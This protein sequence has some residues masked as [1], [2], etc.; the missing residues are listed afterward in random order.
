MKADVVLT[1]GDYATGPPDSDRQLAALLRRFLAATAR[2]KG[3]EFYAA[4][5]SELAVGLH[6]KAVLVDEIV[7]ADVVEARMLAGWVD[8]K[9]LLECRF[10]VAETP[11]AEVLRTNGFVRLPRPG[12]RTAGDPRLADLAFA[13][14]LAAPL[15]SADG[16]AIGVLAVVSADLAQ[17]D[18]RARPVLGFFASCAAA[19]LERQRVITALAAGEARYRSVLETAADAILLVDSGGTIV[20]ANTSAELMFAYPPGSLEGQCI[21]L[22]VPESRRAGHAAHRAR[23][24]AQPRHGSMRAARLEGQRRDGSVFPAEISLS[25]VHHDS[26]RIITCAVRDVS[27]R[28]HQALALRRLNASLRLLHACN[29]ALVR[30]GSESEIIA[31]IVDLL[32]RQ[33]GYS[34]VWVDRLGGDGEM[35]AE[36]AAAIAAAALDGVCWHRAFRA[37]LSSPALA[38]G[39]ALTCL[40][41][42]ADADASWIA[43]LAGR[44]QRAAIALPLVARGVAVGVLNLLTPDPQGFDDDACELLG[45]LADDLAC[46]IAAQRAE[47]GM[48][49]LQRAV[50]ASA[51]GV[52]ITDAVAPDHPITYVNP[53]F[54]AI[55]G[56]LSA[57]VLG[58]SGRCLLGAGRDQLALNE[59][60][61]A[62]R[63]RRGTQV[64]LRCLRK[65]GAPLW[66]ELNLSPV[67]SP[68]GTL[69]HF[70]SVFHD[71]SERQRYEEELEHQA[72]HDSL[73]GLAN[74]NLL[75]DRQQQA[76][77]YAERHDAS[78]AVLA[79]DVDQFK[80]VNDSLGHG[81]G[82]QLLRVVAERLAESVRD[83]DTV[84]RLGGDEFVI[85]LADPLA[86]DES[87]RVIARILERVARPL[88]VGGQQLTMSCSI[89]AS[90]YPRDG[91]D[92]ET[93]LKNADAA[94]HRAKLAGR[95]S[96]HFYQ[97]E[98]NERIA[99]QLTLEAD[100]ARAVERGELE[101]HYQPQV[102][103]RSG[104]IVGAEALLRWRHATRGMIA[105]DDFI[106]LAEDTGLIVPIGQWVI[107]SA[108]QQLRIW[109]D[110]GLKA[111]RLAVNLSARQ[112]QSD[113]LA[114]QIV[115]AIERAGLA[116]GALEVELTESLA[117]QEIAR[118]DAM[119]RK[120]R[121][122]G[123][124]TAIDDFGTG[125]SSLSQ[126]MRITVDRIKI[127]R[128]FVRDILTDR[129]AAAVS[130]AVMAMARSLDVKV[131][132]E[133]VESEGQ[134]RFLRDRGCDEMQGFYFSRP[135][136]LQDFERLLREARC[137]RS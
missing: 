26:G 32:H 66:T 134:L 19:E 130:L 98:M 22:L 61:Q 88:D 10:P 128:C 5:V 59:L 95:G 6:A 56:Y 60:R 9:L 11:A 7:V 118:V 80:R 14:Y 84:A 44:G 115:A 126:L 120:I 67:F 86:E 8:G 106:A 65:D 25:Y 15:T 123:V 127:D 18:D 42:A 27:E 58:G 119:L 103:L 102:D 33:G 55:T 45:E 90:I 12:A 93:L 37:Q 20:L 23:F 28:D 132:A 75:R 71:I 62:L 70:V 24:D 51:N 133:G 81:H 50:E 52:M 73:T 83:G 36:P 109:R 72:N 114:D 43:D 101:L 16:T 87:A 108:C 117:L 64:T 136:P 48:L 121:A 135:L 99:D 89:G 74:R 68:D 38:Q 76:I 91:R 129:T 21:D 105:P 107:D 124:T 53:G 112:F 46:G 17:D 96:F 30:A 40:F 122:A 85:V 79:V 97:A 92:P 4:L 34:A 110:A 3:P 116:A 29:A 31:A 41:A 1:T 39:R 131:V 82:D 57:D 77:A 49:L 13:S 125:F 69:G 47:A 94:M 137:L 63:E 78:L 35:A 104:E 54:E 100:L 111:P 113:D 2:R